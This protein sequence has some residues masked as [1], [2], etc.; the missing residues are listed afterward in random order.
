MSKYLTGFIIFIVFFQNLNAQKKFEITPI[1]GTTLQIPYGEVADFWWRTW[2]INTSPL[3]GFELKKLNSNYAVS[4]MQCYK[5]LNYV[6]QHPSIGQT[7]RQ[8]KINFYYTS[9]KK[10]S[11]KWGIGHIWE[12]HENGINHFLNY[13]TP[14]ERGL[15]FNFSYRCNYLD[16]EVS[17]Y[18]R[19]YPRP[20]FLDPYDIA[21]NLIY[22]INKQ[23]NVKSNDI[24]KIKL[25][26]LLGFKIFPTFDMTTI[27]G[28]RTTLVG[29]AIHLGF[30]F[31][32]KPSRVSFNLERDWWLGINGGSRIRDIR[33]YLRNS[34]LGFR[35][36]FKPKENKLNAPKIGIGYAFVTDSELLTQA[37]LDLLDGKTDKWSRY[38]H[39]V[40][41]IAISYAHPIGNKIDVEVRN[42]FATVGDKVFHN[43]R[44]S[45]GIT[46]RF[47]PN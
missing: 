42:I 24:K 21:I 19:Y 40:K 36:H 43:R 27:G 12:T 8:N 20:S 15:L 47:N 17:K 22:R 46:Y 1:I 10:P 32:H 16:I 4:F 2:D 3:Y 28:E 7:F 34:I 5:Y 11:R 35:Y 33:G 14:L 44:L 38:F 31:L 25:N 45:I 18:A 9:K 41:G 13:P 23:T 26:T 37:R 39:N 6:S 30:E 29:N